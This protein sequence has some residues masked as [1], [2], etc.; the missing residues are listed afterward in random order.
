MLRGKISKSVN[1]IGTTVEEPP[2]EE[3]QLIIMETGIG[4][5]SII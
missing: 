2:V 3:P 1:V 5:I 4:E